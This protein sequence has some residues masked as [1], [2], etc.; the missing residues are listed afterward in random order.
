MA[1][2]PVNVPVEI[3]SGRLV[4]FCEGIVGA[5]QLAIG[6]QISIRCQGQERLLVRGTGGTSRDLTPVS[7]L[8]VYCAGKP[9]TAL[10]LS[11]E[12]GSHGIGLDERIGD[13]LGEVLAPY[14]SHISDYTFADLLSHST[15]M[16]NPVGKKI[17]RAPE[18]A[19][20][21]LML[22]GVTRTASGGIGYSEIAAWR[23]LC[24]AV[25][26][27]T[28]RPAAEVIR[29]EIREY[30]GLEHTTVGMT[31]DD[32][33]TA[34]VE[35]NVT[36]QHGE[37]IPMLAET[38]RSRLG[39]FEPGVGTMSTA[40]DL[41]RFYEW[42]MNPM[43]PQGET[44]PATVALI[45]RMVTHRR[46]RIYDAGFLRECS[47]GLG[48]MV[49]LEDHHYGSSTS[50]AAYGHSGLIGTAF[51]FADPAADLAVGVILVGITD[52]E[53]TGTYLRPTLVDNIVRTAARI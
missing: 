12:L 13:H 33:A 36:L 5:K 52:E 53:S 3:S 37:R 43:T 39:Y 45:D 10:A 30:I 18:S 34:I 27:T 48:L 31:E 8:R 7:R 38:S 15:T 17:I 32:I 6:V 49:D 47:F 2:S 21:Q 28:G 24:W 41:S 16:T 11:R 20:P 42:T 29:Q 35:P 51:G 44:D 26:S 4:E 1:D 25:E 14:P 23:M 50:T 40:S 46:E 22:D 19:M 9:I